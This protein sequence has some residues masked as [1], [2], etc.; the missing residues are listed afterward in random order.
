MIM[1]SL[2]DE[3]YEQK[4]ECL[5]LFNFSTLDP[6]E[7]C[8]SG[9]PLKNNPVPLTIYHKHP[10]G[11]LLNTHLLKCTIFLKFPVQVI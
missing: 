2:P 4:I 11:I 9:I 7:M 10:N 1:S 5:I 3:T 8:R 6:Y